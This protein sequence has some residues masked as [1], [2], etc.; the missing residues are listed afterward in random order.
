MTTV[1]QSSC[2][3]HALVM[4]LAALEGHQAVQIV[5]QAVFQYN[6]SRDMAEK[7][8]HELFPRFDQPVPRDSG[9]LQQHASL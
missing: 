3:S 6:T 8:G 5:W 2:P 4:R 1:T 9:R 7:V